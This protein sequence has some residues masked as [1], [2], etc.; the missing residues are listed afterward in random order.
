MGWMS[1]VEGTDVVGIPMDLLAEIDERLPSVIHKLGDWKDATPSSLSQ[2]LALWAVPRPI[3][4]DLGDELRYFDSI[5]TVDPVDDW[6]S[7]RLG[8]SFQNI[9]E[10]NDGIRIATGRQIPTLLVLK[11]Y[12]LEEYFPGCSARLAYA[13][14]VG[15]NPFEMAQQLNQIEPDAVQMPE[16]AIGNTNL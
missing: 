11:E 9:C 8:V 3:I 13:E 4:V 6:E 16:L 10:T 7:R 14:A 5:L 2:T 12:E 15:M 1:G